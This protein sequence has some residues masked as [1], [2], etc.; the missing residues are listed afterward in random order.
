MLLGFFGIYNKTA[1]ELSDV[2]EKY[3]GQDAS[4]LRMV[5]AR[6]M[7]N[8]STET[9]MGKTLEGTKLDL[10]PQYQICMKAIMTQMFWPWYQYNFIFQFHNLFKPMKAAKKIISRTVNQLIE[11]N[12]ND[13]AINNNNNNS[14]SEERPIFIKQA[15]KLAKE[16]KFT[17]EDVDVQ[18]NTIV[19]GVK[20]LEL[21]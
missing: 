14:E 5:F 8:T 13:T 21:Y 20:L 18:S 19:V 9:T 4:D 17:M 12:I 16:N 2:L 3:V 11:D 10:L 1:N 6:S 15:I 7:I